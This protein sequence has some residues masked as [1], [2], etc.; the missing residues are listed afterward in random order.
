[1]KDVELQRVIRRHL[2]GGCGGQ[3]GEIGGRVL[4]RER[5]KR[6]TRRREKRTAVDRV[7]E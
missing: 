6:R 5:L 3:K 4:G 7:S 2:A 1:M